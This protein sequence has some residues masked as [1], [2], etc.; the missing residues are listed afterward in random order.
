MYDPAE[1]PYCYPG[2]TVLRNRAG[3]RDQAALD[4]FEHE[5]VLQR[6]SEPMAVRSLGVRQYRAVHRHLFGDVYPW[7]GQ[8]RTVRIAKGGN[9]FCYPEHIAAAIDRLFAGLRRQRWLRR[10]SADDFAR[11]AAHFLA[12]LNAI[13][14][15]REG[16]GRTRLVFLALL[17]ERA[18][19]PLDFERMNPATMLAAMV[20]SFAGDEAPLAGVLR[21]LLVPPDEA[22]P[23]SPENGPDTPV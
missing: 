7:A 3:L 15:F 13:H 23:A 11:H 19:H 18:G 2:T 14:P 10:L 12:E 22:S 21:A 8:F 16:N 9:P 4:V 17:A 6:A 1:D 5:A 20:R